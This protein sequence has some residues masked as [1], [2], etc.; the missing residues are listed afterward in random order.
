MP[1]ISTSTSDHQN[2]GDA[3]QHREQ[4]HKSGLDGKVENG[5]SG[6]RAVGDVV[7]TDPGDVTGVDQ[8]NAGDREAAQ[9]VEKT[10]S[11]VHVCQVRRRYVRG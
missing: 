11:S 6:W 9:G 1:T 7:L 5:S 3:E 8:Q 10:V 4:R 2:H